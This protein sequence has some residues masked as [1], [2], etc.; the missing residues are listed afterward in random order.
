MQNWSLPLQDHHHFKLFIIIGKKYAITFSYWKKKFLFRIHS[1]P[2]Y[3]ISLLAF[4]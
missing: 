4:I 2:D 3:Q 1:H